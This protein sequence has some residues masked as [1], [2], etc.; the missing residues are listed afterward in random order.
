MKVMNK[1][2]YSQINK[3]SNPNGVVFFGSNFFN[4]IP[5]YELTKSL[6]IEENI[7]NRSIDDL[8]IISA[9]DSLNICVFELSPNKI[10][11]NIGENDINKKDFEIDD[12]IQKYEWMLYVIARKT[13]AKIFVTSIVSEADVVNQVNSKLEALS[14]EHGC[15]Y[16]DLSFLVNKDDAG[17]KAFELMK[18]YIRNHPLTFDEIMSSF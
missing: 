3:F 15:K 6:G 17:I 10:F 13:D 4:T 7:Y 2:D 18:I 16:V 1:H 11:I 14:V 9:T 12:F 8:D 5:V